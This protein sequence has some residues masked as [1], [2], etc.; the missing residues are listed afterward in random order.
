M[1]MANARKRRQ[2]TMFAGVIAAPVEW[3]GCKY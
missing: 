3:E 1:L 2:I